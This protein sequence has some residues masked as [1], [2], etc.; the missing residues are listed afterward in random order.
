MSV[1]Y[2]SFTFHS[3]IAS[4][5]AEIKFAVENQDSNLKGKNEIN[6]LLSASSGNYIHGLTRIRSDV[7]ESKNLG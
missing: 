6:Y 5:D 7:K 1:A 4:S 2:A 3:K